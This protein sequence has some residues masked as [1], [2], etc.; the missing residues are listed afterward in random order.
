MK[1]ATLALMGIGL[2]VGSSIAIGQAPTPKGEPEMKTV[3]QKFSY[4]IGLNLGRSI[5]AEEVG[6]DPELIY[7]GIKDALADKPALTEAQ[8][9]EVQKAFNQLM[10]A[11]Q[12]EIQAKQAAAM[13]DPAKILK[14]GQDFLAANK[15]KPGVVPLPSGVQYKVIKSGTGK[16]PKLTDSVVANYK[17]TLIDGTE[18][19]SSYKRGQ[20]ATFGVSQVIKGWTEILQK[21]KV[22]DKWEV[23][24]P[25]ELAYGANPRPGGKIRPNDAL[26]FEIELLDVK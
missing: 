24:I 14:E 5:K 26:I 19:D 20:P 1:Y 12:A 2:A 18:F 21:M 11:K 4:A 17:G 23:Y 22:G 6:L 3:E 25:S 8:L 7:K 10:M 13:G 16:S 9:T 15:T